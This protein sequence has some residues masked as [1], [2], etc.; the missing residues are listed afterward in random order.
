M[1]ESDKTQ[2]VDSKPEVV[3]EQWFESFVSLL[4]DKGVKNAAIFTHPFPDPDAIGSMLG[5]Q[6]LL[7]KKYNIDS[8]IFYEGSISHPQNIAMCNLLD[9]N[10]IHVEEFNKEKFNFFVLLDTIPSHAGTGKNKVDFN[11]I[12]DHHRNNVVPEGSLLI[13]LKAGSCCG[14]IYNIMKKLELSFDDDNDTDTKIATALL[15]G[16]ATDTENLMS[17]DTTEFEIKSWQDSF[18][19]ANMP[20]LKKIVNFE[21]PK[22]WIDCQAQAIKDAVINEEGI[23][24][25]GLGIISEKNR[26]V[27]ADIADKMISWENVH[28]AIVF[29]IIEGRRI[30]GSVRSANASVAVPKLCKSL[31]GEYGDG[32]GKLGKGA[33]SY[34]LSGASIDQDDDEEMISKT[35]EVLQEKEH[36]RIARVMKK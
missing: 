20:L 28:T 34:I 22:I 27:I 32:G 2:K 33:Y 4:Q 3:L 31:G 21:R 26:D 10:L 30:E 7:N 5:M 18:Q 14:T 29:A 13:N 12:I 6:W 19:V 1:S 8:T 36:R 35:C 17:D 23:G 15:I 9:V 16:V 11:V 24:V 25:V